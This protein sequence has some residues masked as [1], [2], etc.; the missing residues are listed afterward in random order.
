MAARLVFDA[1]A[2]PAVWPLHGSLLTDIDRVLREVDLEAGP[3]A[4]AVPRGDRERRWRRRPGYSG[5]SR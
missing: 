5:R 2:E 4:R 3:E 1:G